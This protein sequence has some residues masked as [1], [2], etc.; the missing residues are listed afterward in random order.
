MA[1]AV[2]W[3]ELENVKLRIAAVV[4]AY[5]RRDLM[6]EALTALAAQTRELDSIVVVDNASTDGSADLAAEKYPSVDVVRLARNTGGAG[7]FAVGIERAISTHAADLVWIMDDDTI[8]SATALAELLS[9]RDRHP[10]KPVVLASRVLW[11][12]GSDHPMNTPRRK[13]FLGRAERAAAETIGAIPVRSSSFVST[14][15]DAHAVSDSGLPIAEYFIWND[16]FEFTA[17]LLRHGLGVYCPKSIVTHKTK[18]LASTDVDPGPRFYYEVR[19]KLWLF[20][21]S[22][23]LAPWEVPLYIGASL[24]RWTRTMLR[25]TDRPTLID[26][27]RRGLRDGFR[28]A[29]RPNAVF[30]AD[31]EP[32][33][34]DIARFEGA[35]RPAAR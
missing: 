33:T 22:S 27:L 6:L 17:R 15:V 20:R 34:S 28:T 31:L 9:I 8:P 21:R 11:T 24:I 35:V 12:D 19:N 26:G 18:A 10:R 30:L 14:L 25:S 16:D 23:A 4:V 13:P 1:R 2:D 3:P 32:A 5:N 7:G 29:P